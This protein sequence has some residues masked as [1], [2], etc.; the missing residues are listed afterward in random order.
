MEN[1]KPIESILKL[2]QDQFFSLEEKRKNMSKIFYNSGVGSL[3]YAMVCKQLQ[4]V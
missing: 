4:I 1:C 3:M 2:N